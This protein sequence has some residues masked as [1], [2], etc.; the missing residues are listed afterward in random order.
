MV[1]GA[2][3]PRSAQAAPF[4]SLNQALA[5]SGRA[6]QAAI[7]PSNAVSAT[8]Q[9]TLGAQNLATAAIRFR[10]LADALANAGTGTNAGSSPLVIDGAGP[11]TGLQTAPGAAAGGP[12]WQGASLPTSA[13]TAQ[14]ITVTVT[15]SK[16]LAQLTWRSFNV[17]RHT[18][19]DFNQSAGGTLASS[20]VVI[21]KV[22]DP[23]ANGSLIEGA[24][25]AQGKV[26][27]LNR[28]GI[29]FT[30]GSTINVGSLIAA[31]ADIAANQFA[32]SAAGL[33]SFSLYGTQTAYTDPI[34]HLM[35]AYTPTF[36]NGTAASITV[37]PGAT[38]QTAAPTGINAGGYAM[39][40]GGNVSNGGLIATPQGQ[41]ILAAGTAF[42]LRQG[43]QG[44]VTTGNLTSTTLGSEIATTNY[45]TSNASGL[46]STNP[47]NVSFSTGSVANSGIVTADRGDI[48]LAGHALT[49]AGVL[50]STTT[51]D[52]RGTIHF[53][54]AQRRHGRQ[55]QHHAGT[56]LAHRDRAR[57]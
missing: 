53:P 52:T 32:T 19:L 8:K 20:W 26:I 4:R 33:T 56:R 9:A 1:A 6:V 51:V 35:A 54:D 15:Q 21:N 43:T 22:L 10:S 17:G 44:S 31:T 2:A 47:V 55:R 27:V 13:T 42:T 39:L 18:T 46:I 14:G 34:S 7:A 37:A 40:L 41:T 25:N 48:T 38:I 5:L 16:P 24:I 49:Q 57:G 45:G 3:A 11:G 28:N 50:L 36:V 12:L 23:A 30:G 29:A